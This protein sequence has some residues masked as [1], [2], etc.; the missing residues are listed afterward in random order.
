MMVHLTIEA[1]NDLERIGDFIAEDNPVRAISFVQELREKCL[2][3]SDM[4]RAFPLM[5]SY[6]RSGIRRRPHGDYLIFYRAEEE[7]VVIIH[8]LHGAMDFEPIL[9]TDRHER[10][11]HP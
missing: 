1:E 5:P 4:A 2:S 6:E 3:L 8:V 7:S 9:S 11:L 10:G